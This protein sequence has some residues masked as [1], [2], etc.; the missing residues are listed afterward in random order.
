MPISYTID[1]ADEVVYR[2]YTDVVAYDDFA[3]HWRELLAD[4]DLPSEGPLLLVADMRA[5][6]IDLDGESVLRLVK[7]VIQ[8]LLNGRKWISAVV[9][10]FPRDFGT[11]RQFSGCSDTCGETGVFYEVE[12]AMAWLADRRS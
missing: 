1:L 8:P 9:V 11:T 2:T 5:A 10:G 3:E 12:D 4:P 7:S 6:K